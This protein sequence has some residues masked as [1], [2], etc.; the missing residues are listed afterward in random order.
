VTLR[1]KR[2]VVLV[3]VLLGLVLFLVR[4]G[5]TRLKTRIA[6]SIGTALQRQVEIGRVHIRFLPRPGFDLENFVVH[7]DP[8]FGAEPVLRAQDV[9]AYLRLTSLLHGHLEIARLSLTEPS[10]NIVRREDGHWNIENFLERTATITRAAAKSSSESHPAMPYIEADRGRI[11]FKIGREKKPFAITDADYAFWQE[12]QN[13][14]GM[15][16]KGQ[17]V[18]TDF[19]VTDTGQLQM[20]GSW[21]GADVLSQTPLRFNLQWEG[22]QLG[23]FSKLLS[24]R[25][26]G[27]RG[28][29]NVSIGG[30]GTPADLHIAADAALLDFRRYDIPESARLELKTHCD[31]RYQVAD[32][33]LHEILCQSPVGDGQLSLRGNITNLSAPTHYEARLSAASVP[34]DALLSFLRRAKKNLPD[35]LQADGTVDGQFKLNVE[36]ASVSIEGR[37]Q[38]TEFHLRTQTARNDLTFDAIPFSVIS[39]PQARLVKRTRAAGAHASQGIEPLPP[40]QTRLVIGPFPVKLGR[41]VPA[42]VQGWFARS[43]YGFSLK[44]DADLQRLVSLARA[45]GLPAVQPAATGSARLDLEIA[46]VWSGFPGPEITGK[47]ELHQVRAEFR[48]LSAPVEI[49]SAKLTL[50]ER[51]THVEA[52]S[53][54]AAGTEWTGTLDLPRGCP[55]AEPCRLTFDLHADVISTD[56]IHE[57][58]VSRTAKQPWYEFPTSA[59]LSGPPLL[60]SIRASGTLTADHVLIRDLSADHCTAKVELE[61][62]KLRLSD[63]R[64]DVLGGEHH[65]E[66]RADFNVKPPTYSGTGTFDGISLSHLAD[67]MHENWISGT[68]DA[69]YELAFSGLSASEVA[70]SAKGTL[71]FDARDGILP[72]FA[73]ASTP[74]RIRRFTGVLD[75][76]HGEFT[77]Q[78]AKLQSPAANYLMTGSASMAQRLDLKLVQ[79]GSTAFTVTGTLADPRVVAVRH[80]ETQAALKP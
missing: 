51:Q 24:G 27:W 50:N 11:N 14:W 34:L 47:A 54:S 7:D 32:H 52:L 23:Q 36:G 38:T 71:Q 13:T 59:V 9:A 78:D 79:K 26:K 53:V 77:L 76:A 21:A 56:L 17:P 55:G 74:L 75:L 40:E 43:G 57:W 62:G 64:A 48:G 28:A 12:S 63:L 6:T 10:F 61:Q 58:L 15:R 5:A 25:D 42:S 4:P 72:R 70:E 44:G 18:R 68:A 22:A 37:G 2:G 20:S 8:S 65:G 49:A 29:M 41:P 16:L 73:L 69:R 19:N 45:A 80:A 31:A 3:C 1:S 67:V 33:S 66:W 30:T 35:D 46:G 60:A 39:G